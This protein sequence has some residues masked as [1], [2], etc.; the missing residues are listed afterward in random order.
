M[1][2]RGSHWFK[3]HVA[4]LCYIVPRLPAS[5]ANELLA[6]SSWLKLAQVVGGQTLRGNRQTLDVAD[7]K[8][9][10][11]RGEDLAFAEERYRERQ[12]TVCGVVWRNAGHLQHP[13]SAAD[14]MP[15]AIRGTEA[16][17]PRQEQVQPCAVFPGLGQ[18][19]AVDQVA[20]SGLEQAT[21]EVEVCKSPEPSCWCSCH[22]GFLSF[23]V[24]FWAGIV[25]I[26]S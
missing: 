12:A 23:K 4:N 13:R 5:G 6:C 16:S 25:Q 19:T 11:V 2:A 9:T 18:G 17:K 14:V 26:P 15:F 8:L 24:L 21:L 3:E 20:Y 7:I 22:S 10:Q 1:S